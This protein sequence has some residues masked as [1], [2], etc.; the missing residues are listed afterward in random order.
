VNEFRPHLEILPAAQK[1]LWLELSAVPDQFVLY[2]GTALARHLG[3]RTS[4]DFDFFF[5]APAES[6]TA[7]TGIPFL[8][9]AKTIQREKNMLTAIV[10]RGDPVKVSF[11]GVPKLPQ[12]QVPHVVNEKKI[13]VAS[14]LDLAGTKASE[15]QTQSGVV[16][17]VNVLWY[18][19]EAAARLRPFGALT[20]RSAA[21]VTSEPLVRSAGAH[22]PTRQAT[23]ENSSPR[24]PRC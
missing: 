14:L 5:P 19:R 11:F 2:G 24:S 22:V 23:Q 7:G 9:G 16:L 10:V 4:I 12:L 18:S 6:C 1:R 3:H 21:N 15:V 13:G 20:A 17:F 8:A